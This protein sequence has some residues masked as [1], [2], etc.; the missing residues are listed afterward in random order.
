MTGNMA[1]NALNMQTY[2][3]AVLVILDISPL[4]WYQSPESHFNPNALIAL[5]APTQPCSYM[6][7]HMSLWLLCF[8]GHVHACVCLLCPYGH[9][10]S[11]TSLWPC[12][13]LCTPLAMLAN[14]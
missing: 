1:I 14:T 8:Y 12:M 7:S 4:V 13:P 6:C 10:R 9:L 5:Y 2:K 3:L 11:C